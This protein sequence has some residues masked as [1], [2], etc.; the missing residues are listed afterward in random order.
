MVLDLRRS[1][2]EHVNPVRVAWLVV[3]LAI[4]LGAVLLEAQPAGAATY[5]TSQPGGYRLIGY[6]SDLLAG[7][8]TAAMGVQV[9]DSGRSYRPWL[10]VV[11]AR[12]RPI[13]VM[14]R[15]LV[16]QEVGYASFKACADYCT[17]QG[18][19]R[20]YRVG[21]WR[22]LEPSDQLRTY[23][24]HVWAHVQGGSST[25]EECVSSL[26]VTGRGNEIGGAVC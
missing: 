2:M 21:S 16:V 20:I 17:Y 18:T 15:R 11:D 7:N 14:V 19:G 23:A 12:N 25:P 3:L 5:P 6:H 26:L 24:H 13:V 4:A 1:R 9:S 10:R 8:L 22:P